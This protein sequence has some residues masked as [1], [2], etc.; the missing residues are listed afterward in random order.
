[1]WLFKLN[2]HF[3]QDKTNPALFGTKRKFRNAKY[4]NIVYNGAEIK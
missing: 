2:M 1:M 4:L 3:D